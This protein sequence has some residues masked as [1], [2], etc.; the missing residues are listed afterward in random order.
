MMVYKNT[1]SIITRACWRNDQ[2]IKWQESSL[3]LTRHQQAEME[4]VNERKKENEQKK[5]RRFAVAK[6]PKRGER[7]KSFAIYLVSFDTDRGI[8]NTLNH[9]RKRTH[10]H[11]L[12]HSFAHTHTQRHQQHP[13]KIHIIFQDD[14][15]TSCVLALWSRGA[16]FY[17][18]AERKEE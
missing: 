5:K 1:F 7:E 17:L 14:G 11:I 9:K 13:H 12:T 2:N 4:D 6:T 3:K 10:S 16:Q 15:I 8:R 18:S